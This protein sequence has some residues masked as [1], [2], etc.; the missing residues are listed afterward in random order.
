MAYI[1][2]NQKV[3]FCHQHLQKNQ[4][5]NLVKGQSYASKI[6]Y[7]NSVIRFLS[8]QLENNKINTKFA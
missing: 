4:E 2:K 8:P 6:T 5:N 3:T 7:M 1:N